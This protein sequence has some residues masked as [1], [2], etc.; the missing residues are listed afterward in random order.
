MGEILFQIW[1][2]PTDLTRVS[3]S[4]LISMGLVAAESATMQSLVCARLAHW[5]PAGHPCS[6]QTRGGSCKNDGVAQS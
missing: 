6:L 4:W 3:M 2:L 1:E 5:V